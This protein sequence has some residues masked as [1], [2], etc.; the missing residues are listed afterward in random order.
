[1]GLMTGK[2]I[3]I[4]AA[5]SGFGKEIALQLT[6]LGGEIV[7]AC[8]DRARGKRPGSQGYTRRVL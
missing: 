3:I 8:S 6:L 4:T 1:M 2:R 7:L 5:T